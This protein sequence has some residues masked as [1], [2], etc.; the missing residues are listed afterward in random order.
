[1]SLKSAPY[2]WIECDD[3]GTKSTENSEHS[4]W[5]DHGHARDEAINSDWYVEEDGD[6]CDECAPKRGIRVC[7]GCGDLKPTT[8]GKDDDDWCAECTAADDSE[9]TP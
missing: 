7:A 4:A 5:S 1:M 6:Y 2:F 3:C 8:R 9:V